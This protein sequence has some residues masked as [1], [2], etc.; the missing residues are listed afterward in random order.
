MDLMRRWMNKEKYK[1]F[2]QQVP[3]NQFVAPDLKMTKVQ[4]LNEDYPDRRLHFFEYFTQQ[5]NNYYSLLYNISFLD[6]CTYAHLSRSKQSQVSLLQRYQ[7]THNTLKNL[8]GN[9]RD[10]IVGALFIDG[11]LSG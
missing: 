2:Q 4:G 10:Y 5:L 7:N 1:W 3:N 11:H 9:L 6:E 8:A